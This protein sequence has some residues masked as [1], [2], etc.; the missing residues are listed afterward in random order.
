MATILAHIRVTPGTAARYE[1]LAADLYRD[2]HASET[3]V[4]YY[5][6]WRGAEPDTYY[7]L[8]AFEDYRAFLRHQTSPHHADFAVNIRGVIAELR[9]EWVDPVPGAS[10]LGPTRPQNPPADAD[11]DVRA[12][13]AR[14][15]A[16]PAEWWGNVTG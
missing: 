5:E 7:T 14:Y 9:L 16:V 6:H 1:Q 3:G 13:A 12:T 15:P 11:E 2:T 10:A 8:L 4:R